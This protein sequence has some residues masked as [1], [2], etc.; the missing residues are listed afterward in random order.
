MA[1]E[2]VSLTLYWDYLLAQYVPDFTVKQGQHIVEKHPDLYRNASEMVAE[3]YRDLLP[4]LQQHFGLGEINYGCNYHPDGSRYESHAFY[5]GTLPSK[6]ND[7][8]S[9]STLV[10]PLQEYIDLWFQARSARLAATLRPR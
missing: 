2:G 9:L 8:A 1:I 7:P 3:I 6:S 10:E 5:V 4:E